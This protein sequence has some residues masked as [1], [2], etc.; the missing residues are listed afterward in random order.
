MLKGRSVWFFSTS[1]PKLSFGGFEG[2]SKK[3]MYGLLPKNYYPKTIYINPKETLQS[4]LEKMNDNSFSYPF[5]VKPDVGMEGILFRKI[6]TGS[7][8]ETYHTRMPIDYL[9][10]EFVDYP[11]EIGLFYIRHPQANSGKIT[12]FFSKKF[13]VIIGDGE[14]TIKEILVKEQPEIN[15]ELSKLTE[16][17]LSRILDKNQIFNLSFIGNRYHGVT[18]HDLSDHIDEKLLKLFDKISISSQFYYGRYDI[19]CSSVED[20]KNGTNFSILEFN[21]AGSIPNHIYTDKFTLIEAYKEIMKH[22]KALYDISSYIHRSGIKY[23]SLM[24]GARYL[25][26][27]KKHFRFLRRCDGSIVLKNSADKTALFPE[28]INQPRF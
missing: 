20:L 25:F 12:G 10:Q 11:L 6:E 23:W 1:N 21:G 26:N 9:M 2:E 22:W 7:H 13:P 24:E 8:L 27:A 15:E 19:K 5:I 4:V 16:E 3:E 28:S 14:S 18:F 17:E